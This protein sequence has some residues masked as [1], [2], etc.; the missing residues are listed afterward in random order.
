MKEYIHLVE[1]ERVEGLLD[2]TK[3]HVKNADDDRKFHLKGVKEN[4]LLL[5][6]IPGWVNSHW[7]YAIRVSLHPILRIVTRVKQIK[8]DR[9]EVVVHYATEN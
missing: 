4:Q 5:C 8:W 2:E 7:V 3:H 1:V 9:H 6:S